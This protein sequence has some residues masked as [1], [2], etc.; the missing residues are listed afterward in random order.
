MYQT[1]P[2]DRSMRMTCPEDARAMNAADGVDGLR[3]ST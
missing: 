1:G 2:R 3:D